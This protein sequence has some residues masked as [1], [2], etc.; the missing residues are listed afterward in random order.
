V[1]IILYDDIPNSMGNNCGVIT[2]KPEIDLDFNDM[3]FCISFNIQL[4]NTLLA[5]GNYTVELANTEV[6]GY[7]MLFSDGIETIMVEIEH[8]QD[9]PFG[10]IL[11]IQS[12]FKNQVQY[13]AT[14]VYIKGNKIVFQCNTDIITTISGCLEPIMDKMHC[15]V[16]QSFYI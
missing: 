16:I 14:L 15:Y 1:N 11:F 7:V 6:H 9:T 8:L 3:S 5:T 12:T 2:F 10:K 13:K 4:A